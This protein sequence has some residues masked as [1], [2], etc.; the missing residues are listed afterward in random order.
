MDDYRKQRYVRRK[1]RDLNTEEEK[2]EVDSQTGSVIS[3]TELAA[4][5]TAQTEWSYLQEFTDQEVLPTRVDG[6]P[7]TEA[8]RAARKR[9]IPMDECYVGQLR[10]VKP[11]LRHDNLD[12]FVDAIPTTGVSN[13]V[14]YWILGI[15]HFNPNTEA[16]YT[17][18]SVYVVSDKPM[19]ALG[20]FPVCS[21]PV[22]L[23]YPSTILNKINTPQWILE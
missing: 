13:G 11:I 15:S 1:F 14:V 19:A 6:V 3:D 10:V 21:P 12:M 20:G 22:A 2:E 8:I 23:K 16:D 17:N 5:K 4:P 9:K 7:K 18:M